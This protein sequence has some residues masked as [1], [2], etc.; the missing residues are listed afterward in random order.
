MT[1]LVPEVPTE[2]GGVVYTARRNAGEARWQVFADGDFA[3][4]GFIEEH[5]CPLWEG[6]V[7]LMV[8]DRNNRQIGVP[9]PGKDD[10]CV[11]HYANALNF[12]RMTR[13]EPR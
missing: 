2:F 1:E 8:F 9:K 4:A 7:R 5:R 13:E 6:E 3:P 10:G 12:I 11:G